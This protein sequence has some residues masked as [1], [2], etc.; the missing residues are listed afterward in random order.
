MIYILLKNKTLK[1]VIIYFLNII[2]QYILNITIFLFYY[3]H[4]VFF[5]KYYILNVDSVS[6]QYL[7]IMHFSMFL[8]HFLQIQFSKLPWQSLFN[9]FIHLLQLLLFIFIL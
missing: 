1:T 4:I 8:T 2:I 5:T 7:V 3:Q 6:E 9:I